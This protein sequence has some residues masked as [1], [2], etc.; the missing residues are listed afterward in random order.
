MLA[1]DPSINN[2]GWAVLDV[3]A[4]PKLHEV[5]IESGA[6]HP[7]KRDDL[8]DRFTQLGRFMA[9]LIYH[10]IPTDVIVEMPHKGQRG[11]RGFN[12]LMIYSNTAG[13]AAGVSLAMN[14]R[15]WR[16]GV[17]TW[18]GRQQKSAT[19]LTV[20]LVTGKGE[21][22]SSDEIDAIGL[23]LYFTNRIAPS[24][25]GLAPMA[26]LPPAAF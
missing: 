25:L 1:I 15:T 10:F 23:G 11:A 19:A 5:T 14:R 7:S 24:M 18:K 9:E 21:T 6:W 8:P 3:A 2:Y 13:V 12:G 16:I 22:A 17:N 4:K 20:A 26:L